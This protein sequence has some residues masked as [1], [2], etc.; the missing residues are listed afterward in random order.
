MTTTEG[1]WAAVVGSSRE[2]YFHLGVS[3]RSCFFG[4]KSSR[5]GTIQR[6]CQGS[7]RTHR[8]CFGKRQRFCTFPFRLMRYLWCYATLG[9]SKRTS[10][11]L[12]MY[13]D[14]SGWTSPFRAQFCFFI[15]SRLGMEYSW[16]RYYKMWTFGWNIWFVVSIWDESIELYRSHT[17]YLTWHALILVSFLFLHIFMH[18]LCNGQT[19]ER[20]YLRPIVLPKFNAWSEFVAFLWKAVTHCRPMTGLFSGLIPV[21]LRCFIHWSDHSSEGYHFGLQISF[22][23]AVPRRISRASSPSLFRFTS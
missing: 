6:F 11:L 4:A 9:P 2:H 22:Y 1:C 10:V 7:V 12:Q 3:F 15:E 19:I 5:M 20:W 14:R 16:C 21:R 23:L 13:I 8:K 17:W 18:W